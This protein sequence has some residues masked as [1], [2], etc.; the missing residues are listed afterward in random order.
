[1]GRERERREA[2]RAGGWECGDRQG[3]GPRE[4]ECVREKSGVGGVE[5]ALEFCQCSE[6]TVHENEVSKRRQ[7]PK[8]KE[9]ES[10]AEK[11][12]ER[13]SQIHLCPETTRTRGYVPQV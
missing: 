8:K 10:T 3:E 2:V 11:E 5:M 12:R 6:G 9:R 1:M 7:G 4:R 13:E